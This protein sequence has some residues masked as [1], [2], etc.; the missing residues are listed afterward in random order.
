MENRNGRNVK[1][2]EGERRGRKGERNIKK[3]R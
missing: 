3:M 1:Y 2:K